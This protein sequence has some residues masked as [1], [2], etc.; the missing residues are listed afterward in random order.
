LGSPRRA[1]GLFR[2]LPGWMRRN[3]IILSDLAG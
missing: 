1:V 2:K 3:R